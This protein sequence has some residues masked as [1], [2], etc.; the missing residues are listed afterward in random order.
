MKTGGKHI[1]EEGYGS[2]GKYVMG[3]SVRWPTSRMSGS[4]LD[5]E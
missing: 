4:M 5:C 3:W 2:R 1:P